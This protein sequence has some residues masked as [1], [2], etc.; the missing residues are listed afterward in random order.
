MK[1]YKNEKPALFIR[2]LAILFNLIIPGIGLGLLACW[3]SALITQGL[4]ILAVLSLCWSRLVF[5]PWAIKA[6]LVVIVFIYLGSTLACFV[7]KAHQPYKHLLPSLSII[8]LCGVG[9]VTGF[10]YKHYWLGIGIYFVPS[11]SMYPTLKPGEFILVDTWAY[12]K[13]QPQEKDVVVFQQREEQQ[14]LVKRI[15]I[16]PNGSLNN[17]GMYYVLGDNAN[18]SE[19]SRRFGGIPY[20]RIQGKVKLVLVGINAQHQLLENS[21][22]K[23]VQ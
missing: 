23:T 22:L 16:W 17:D 21:Y 5:E 13:Y 8:I 4:L 19:D 10:I 6:S 14:W 3:R 1:T 2:T 11:M 18:A 12:K 7:V 9:F 20:E 15:A